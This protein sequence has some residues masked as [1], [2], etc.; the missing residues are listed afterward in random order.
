MCSPLGFDQSIGTESVVHSRFL[1]EAHV[2]QFSEPETRQSATEGKGIS[3][4]SSRE[5]CIVL[6]TG[7]DSVG[8]SALSSDGTIDCVEGHNKCFIR[9]RCPSSLS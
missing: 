9:V 7:V 3:S 4:P 2:V 1:L 8:S 6:L 5:K